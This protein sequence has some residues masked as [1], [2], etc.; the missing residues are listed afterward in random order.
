[1]HNDGLSIFSFARWS[2]EGDGGFATKTQGW[3]PAGVPRLPS[4]QKGQVDWM[5]RRNKHAWRGGGSKLESENPHITVM[6]W[7][8]LHMHGHKRGERM[9]AKLARLLAKYVWVYR[10]GFTAISIIK[11]QVWGIK[12]NEWRAARSFAHQMLSLPS[13]FPWR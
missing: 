4:L 1:M 9:K 10:R 13:M 7:T 6:N 12:L 8:W 5:L 2:L 11:Q 3:P